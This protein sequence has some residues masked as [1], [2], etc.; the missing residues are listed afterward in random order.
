[1]RKIGDKATGTVIQ[2]LLALRLSAF[3]T[4]ATQISLAA[5]A[6]NRKSGIRIP[7][8]RFCVRRGE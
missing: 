8:R 3:L 7:P 2:S 5:V 1:M 6:A 4:G